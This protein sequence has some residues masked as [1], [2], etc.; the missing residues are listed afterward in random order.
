MIRGDQ[1]AGGI[2]IGRTTAAGVQRLFGRPSTSRV[3]SL[4][5]CVKSWRRVRLQV[6]FFSFRGDPCARRVALIVTVTGRSAWRTGAGLRVGDP[7]ERV[8]AIYPR[9][10]VRS[11][12]RG[13]TGYWLVTR[14]VCVEAGGGSYPGLLARMRNGRVSAL[15]SRLAVCEHE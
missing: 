11:R 7:A 14:Q 10:R 2:R 4:E 13:E 12:F 6:H 8:R 15:V 9:A 5:S 3:L 1:S